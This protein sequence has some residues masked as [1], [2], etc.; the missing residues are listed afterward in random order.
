[1]NEQIKVSVDNIRKKLLSYGSSP[2]T[3]KTF[4]ISEN[5][6]TAIEFLINS[7]EVTSIGNETIL[8]TSIYNSIKQQ[9]FSYLKRNKTATTSELRLSAGTNRRVMIALLEKLD[10]EKIPKRHNDKRSL[11]SQHTPLP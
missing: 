11:I 3:R 6:R 5:D 2:P 10:E 9:I 7:G 4:C 8:I 1:M